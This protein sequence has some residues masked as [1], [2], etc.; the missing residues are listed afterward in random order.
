MYTHNGVSSGKRM[1]PN[2]FYYIEASDVKAVKNCGGDLYDFQF[3]Y[4][5]RTSQSNLPLGDGAQ[6]NHVGYSHVTVLE[7]PNGENGKTEYTYRNNA[8]IPAS[9]P[10]PGWEPSYV[11]NV[12]NTVPAGNG[13][14]LSETSFKRINVA[15]ANRFVEV[16]STTNE[17][18]FSAP[19]LVPGMIVNGSLCPFVTS[20]NHPE[21]CAFIAEKVKFYNYESTW[22]KRLRTTNRIYDQQ[23]TTENSPNFLATSVAY[24]YANPTHLQT[25]RVETTAPDGIVQKQYLRYPADYGNTNPVL[26]AMAGAKHMHSQPVEV[27]YTVTRPGGAEQVVNGLYTDFNQ[28]GTLTLPQQVRILRTNTPLTGLSNSTT[29]GPD[30]R[31]IPEQTISYEPSPAPGNANTVRSPFKPTMSYQWSKDHQ[32]VVGAFVNASRERSGPLSSAPELGNEASWIGFENA[33]T[34]GGTAEDDYW[35]FS[36]SPQSS[37]ATGTAHTGTYSWYVNSTPTG[38]QLSGPGR[39]FSPERQNHRYKLSA[40]VRTTGNINGKLVLVVQRENPADPPLTTAGSYQDQSFGNTGGEWRYVEV[41]LDLNQA[42]PAGNTERLKINAFSTNNGGVGYHIDDMRFQP[43]ESQA[44]TYTYEAGN[45]QP[46]SVS[47]ADS[48][49]QYY[50]FDGLQRVKVVRNFRKEI[51]KQ[52]DYRY[53]K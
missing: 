37:L 25:T 2:K 50:E 41:I 27:Y 44:T 35:S 20:G 49:P 19:V 53:K 11:P 45:P 6:G 30:P 29:A 32:Q 34:Q 7:G 36:T 15:G 1:S 21:V 14:L 13:L 46:S 39:V 17:Y 23:N 38:S 12:P 42:R 10:V 31:Y 8:E 52:F 40:W 28:F 22:I 33:N 47:G 26:A 51:I 9:Y 48:R 5:V 4:A 24:E 43:V 16:A 18:D 3:A